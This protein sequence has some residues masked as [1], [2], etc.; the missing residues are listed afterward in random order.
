MKR[1][2]SHKRSDRE[3]TIAL[4]N[5]VFLMV[6]FFLVAGTLAPAIDARVTLVQA[7]EMTTAPPTDGLLVLVDGTILKS[8]HPLDLADLGQVDGTLRIVPDRDLAARELVRIARLL[9]AAGAD[10]VVVVAERTQP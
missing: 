7:Q 1:R 3:P 5:V 9:R 2:V 4:I 10:G 8:G 6:I